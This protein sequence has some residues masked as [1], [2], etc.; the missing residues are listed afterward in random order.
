MLPG[1][2]AVLFTLASSSAPQANVAAFWDNAQVVVQSLDSGQRNVVVQGGADAR[3]VS[4]GHLLYVRQETLFA[5]PFDPVRLLTTGTPFPVADN[6][7]SATNLGLGGVT[8]GGIRSTTGAAHFAVS[9][10]GLL[11]YVPLD[12]AADAVRTLSW[13][14]RQGRDTALPAPDRA[15]VYPRIS[16][17]GTRVALDIRD[18]EQDI[19]VWDLARETMT[20]FTFD[21]APDIAPVW[22]PDGRR[23]AFSR[24][25]QGLFWAAEGTGIVERLTE[26]ATNPV[27]ST[28]SRDGKGLVFS[29]G[30]APLT[31][32]IRLLD[33][34]LKQAIDLVMQAMVTAQN[35]DISPDGRWLAYQSNES[36]QPEI[37]VRPFPDVQGGRW[38]VSRAGGTRPLWARSG[39][40]LFYLAPPGQSAGGGAESDVA[41]MAVPIEPG[42]VFRALNPTRLFG[43]PYF[44]G[45]NGR[46]YDVSADGQR[47]LM[48]KDKTAGAVS[49]SR[50]IIVVENFFEELKRRAAN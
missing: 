15:Y 39:R 22:T 41:M 21:P 31:N 42:S 23:I 50:R 7:R 9:E 11:A 26:S 5:V 18:Q 33:L 8:T 4:T 1:G 2:K 44:T 38:Q 6:I 37:Y 17:D 12:A 49:A 32:G 29:E 48:I 35:A 43:G 40:E 45:L 3:Y 20:R 19:W 25:G 13:V 16:P 28:F 24:A 10:D 34:E 14:D 30:S 47:F 27:P 46:T 36:G